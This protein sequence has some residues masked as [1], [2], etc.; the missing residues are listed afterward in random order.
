VALTITH[1]DG[2]TTT[3]EVTHDFL[4]DP[5]LIITSAQLA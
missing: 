5:I 4:D 3:A 2:T 1:S